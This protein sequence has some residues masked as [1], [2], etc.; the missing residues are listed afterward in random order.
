METVGILLKK[1]VIKRINKDSIPKILQCVQTLNEEDLYYR[2]NINCNSINNL[3]LHLN[4]NVRQWILAGACG[5]EDKRN[6]Q[7]EFDFDRQYSKKELVN[8][9]MSLE[10]DLEEYVPQINEE[11]LIEERAVQCYTETVL[12]ML[13]HATEHFSYHTGQIVYITKAIKNI[14]TAFYSGDKL[15][16][17]N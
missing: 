13:I 7:S 8:I 9:L 6:R 14:D 4:G 16:Q 12:S 3:I 10:K 2:M 15:D 11:K 5:M 17:I 1:E